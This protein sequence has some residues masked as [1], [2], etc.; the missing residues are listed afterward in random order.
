MQRTGYEYLFAMA[1]A[2]RKFSVDSR[3]Y[4]VKDALVHRPDPLLP[5]QMTPRPPKR[6]HPVI[7]DHP[8]VP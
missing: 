7:I 1:C 8:I 5:M 3:A 2:V 6:P 4:D